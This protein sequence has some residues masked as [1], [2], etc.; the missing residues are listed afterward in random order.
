MIVAQ[1][2][3]RQ[4]DDVFFT[5]DLDLS[6][7]EVASVYAGRWSSEDTSGTPNGG[8]GPQSWKGQVPERAAALSLWTTRRSGCGTSSATACRRPGSLDPGTPPNERRPR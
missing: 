8:E 1:P 3:V 5:T 4:P 6:P 7:E 2:D